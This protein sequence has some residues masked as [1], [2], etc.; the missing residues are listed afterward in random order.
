[1][2]Q[3]ISPTIIAHTLAAACR[4]MP[5][6]M[7]AEAGAL[8]AAACSVPAALASTWAAAADL[9]QDMADAAAETLH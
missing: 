9:L 5:D 1:M 3:P 8:R 4:G 2:C 7:A 6:D